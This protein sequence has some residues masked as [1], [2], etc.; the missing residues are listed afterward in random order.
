MSQNRNF[1]LDNG[2]PVFLISPGKFRVICTL[3]EVQSGASSV[4]RKE[5]AA[6]KNLGGQIVFMG[7]VYQ[8]GLGNGIG[9]G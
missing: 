1:F 6:S 5:V 8:G 2:A 9:E 4:N 7:F 3:R